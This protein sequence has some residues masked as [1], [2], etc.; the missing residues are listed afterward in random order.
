MRAVVPALSWLAASWALLAGC[1]QPDRAA[2][3]PPSAQASEQVRRLAAILDY[4]AA[5][6]RGAV[7]DGRVVVE[8]SAPFV[9]GKLV[10][11]I[12]DRERRVPFHMTISSLGG[13]G[14]DVSGVLIR[15]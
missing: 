11:Q 13:V 8:L 7:A 12:A 2:V 9:T 6:Y 1:A 3:A 10:G 14:I 15:E 4:V 5:D